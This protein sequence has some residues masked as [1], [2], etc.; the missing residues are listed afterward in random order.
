MCFTP[1]VL[2]SLVRRTTAATLPILPVDPK[3]LSKWRRSQSRAVKGWVR[4][5]TFEP[6]GNRVLIVPGGD[7]P[8]LALLGR[9]EESLWTWAAAAQRRPP[10][11]YRIDDELGS[12]AATAAATGWALESYRYDAFTTKKRAVDK[13]LVWPKGAD[14]AEVERLVRAGSCSKGGTVAR[15]NRGEPEEGWGRVCSEGS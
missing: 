13:K 3:A 4:A 2:E 1:R 6:R 5:S 9:T 12:D 10:G 15:R 11:R 14:R 7:G 8:A